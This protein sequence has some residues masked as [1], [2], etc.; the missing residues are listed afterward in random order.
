MSFHHLL[1]CLNGCRQTFTHPQFIR[2]QDEFVS[3]S[4]LEKCLSNGCSAVNGCRQN[5][6]HITP[7]H[8]LTS[9][10]DKSWNKSINKYESIIH[11]N[12]CSS[13]KVFW[14]ES[15][16]K[17]AAFTRQNRSKLIHGWILMRDNSRCTFSLEEEYYGL[18]THICW[19][20]CFNFCLLQMITDGLWIIVMFLSDS[21]SDGTHSLHSIHCWDT[22][23]NLMK[24]Q[25]HLGRSEDTVALKL[26]M[27]MRWN[28]SSV[29]LRCG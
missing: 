16:E 19:W 5:E 3:S 11:N 15:G 29:M 25:T 9:G 17:S 8:Q 18:W 12:S 20:I 4:G 13:E 7:V 2:D 6:K 27:C 26:E 24:K 28:R 1:T 23:T 22:S 14:S 10:E 21:H